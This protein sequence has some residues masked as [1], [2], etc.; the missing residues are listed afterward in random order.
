MGCIVL[1][2]DQAGQQKMCSPG[3]GG[4]ARGSWSVAYQGWRL[5]GELGIEICVLRRHA[6]QVK[7]LQL[8]GGCDNVLC[9]H[10]GHMCGLQ[11]VSEQLRLDRS[12]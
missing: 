3:Q 1:C 12:A 11:A 9:A 2:A 6:G 4:R 7:A 8:A 10:W 5:Q